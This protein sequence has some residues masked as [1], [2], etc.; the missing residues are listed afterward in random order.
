MLSVVPLISD[1]ES[2]HYLGVIVPVTVPLLFAEKLRLKFTKPKTKAKLTTIM[3]RSI[4]E[5]QLKSI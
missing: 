1:P 2:G 3:K 5:W 4:R